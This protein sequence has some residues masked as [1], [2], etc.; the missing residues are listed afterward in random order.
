M[1]VVEETGVVSVFERSMC[2]GVYSLT[3]KCFPAG[4][5]SFSQAAA[6]DRVTGMH[7]RRNLDGNMKME[8]QTK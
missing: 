2:V 4:D 8:T 5:G 6:S 7:K 3:L 1:V